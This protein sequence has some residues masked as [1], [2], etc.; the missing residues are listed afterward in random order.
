MKNQNSRG[1]H[2][3]RL[4]IDQCL[5]ETDI[6][7]ETFVK[8]DQVSTYL[9][10]SAHRTPDFTKPEIQ[11]PQFKVLQSV[12]SLQY[13]ELYWQFWVYF[14]HSKF[15]RPVSS[16]A[17]LGGGAPIRTALRHAIH[18]PYTARRFKCTN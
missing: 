17:T 8:I 1:H 6:R 11:F 13:N 4:E 9:S 2:I 15:I 16:Y 14:D 18:L 10:R 12:F 7:I 5:Q 3:K